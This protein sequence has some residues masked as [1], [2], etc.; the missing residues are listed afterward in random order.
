MASGPLAAT[1]VMA[2]DQPEAPGRCPVEA[3]G[4]ALGDRAWTR[5]PGCKLAALPRGEGTGRLMTTG[6]DL[7]IGALVRLLFQD[8]DLDPLPPK[9]HAHFCKVAVA[10]ERQILYGACRNEAPCAQDQLDLAR[11]YLRLGQDKKAGD[12]YRV[13]LGLLR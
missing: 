11:V 4:E 6:K 8:W 12:R 1:L 10:L 7:D 2:R 5:A 3:V 9:N 13:Y